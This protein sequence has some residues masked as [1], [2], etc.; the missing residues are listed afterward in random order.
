M[1]NDV[2]E[3]LA[4]GMS[5]A[6]M[7]VA[8]S[9]QWTQESNS[10][11]VQLPDPYRQDVL[12]NVSAKQTVHSL[13]QVAYTIINLL[14]R[15]ALHMS[16]VGHF[17]FLFAS[18]S[19]PS[20]FNQLLLS[21]QQ[22]VDMHSVSTCTFHLKLLTNTLEQLREC[23][24]GNISLRLVLEALTEN[25]AIIDLVSVCMKPN[26]SKKKRTKRL[27]KSAGLQLNEVQAT[28]ACEFA[29]IL[30]ITKPICCSNLPLEKSVQQLAG[31]LM[32]LVLTSDLKNT[33]RVKLLSQLS[34]H[35][36]EQDINTL[37]E[38]LLKG[39]LDGTESRIDH[40]DCLVALL[41]VRKSNMSSAEFKAI[42]D[43]AIKRRDHASNEAAQTLQAAVEDYTFFNRA[44]ID[45]SL[46]VD[47]RSFE[48][49]LNCHMTTDIAGLCAVLVRYNPILGRQFGELL[50]NELL[51]SRE[52]Q[53]QQLMK[54][55]KLDLLPVV[56]A[57]FD[58]TGMVGTCLFLH[59]AFSVGCI[60]AC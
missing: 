39:S 38:H 50:C 18:C 46:L 44:S 59:Q 29:N 13:H 22:N 7:L 57:Y 25:K 51:S 40:T 56:C 41:S 26:T 19:S 34:Q 28:L 43:L 10:V 17:L 16:N 24:G 5:K 55:S 58:Q 12:L 31:K 14:S 37:T 35:I 49:L 21:L 53:E 54:M 30:D 42:L 9:V 23:D 32:D 48:S 52:S 1:N 4:C 33:E 8:V 15:M 47:K 36:S 27:T 20:H 2:L 11:A 3:E 6:S 60:P 45:Y